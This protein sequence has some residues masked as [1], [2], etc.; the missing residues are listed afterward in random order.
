MPILINVLLRLENVSKAFGGVKAV[1]D[2]E[3]S[4]EPKRITALIGPNGAGKTTVFNLVC[5]F[6]PVD[7]GMIHFT[8]EEITHAPIW[9]RSRLGLARTF[10]LSRTFKNLS[11]EDNLL[12]S[13]RQDDDQFFAMCLRGLGKDDQEKQQIL[14]MMKFVGLEKSPQTPVTELSYGQ[15]KLFD[16]TR[17]LL[18]PHTLLML[19]EPIAGINP[20]LRERFKELL[21]SLKQKGETIFLIEHDMDFVRAVADWVIVMDQGSVLTQGAPQTVLSDPRVLEAYLGP[22]L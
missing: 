19:D 2:C 15:Q 12:L 17:A 8:D 5:G 9:K 1:Q 14:E 6:F 16:L 20:V 13:V 10:Q 7:A 21:L 22:T 18:N 4:I 3:F 11:I